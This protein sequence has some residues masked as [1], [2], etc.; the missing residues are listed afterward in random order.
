MSAVA[1]PSSGPDLWG[2]LTLWWSLDR[3]NLLQTIG[4]LVSLLAYLA[5]WP[6]LIEVGGARAVLLNQ[7]LHA[8]VLTWMLVLSLPVRTIGTREVVVAWLLG[9]F[10]VPTL[11]FVP[12][13]PFLR[14]L[15]SD[16]WQLA[17]FVAPVLEELALLAGVG[18]LTWRLTRRATRSPGLADLTIIG[19]AVGG[20]YAVHEDALYGRVL[21]AFRTGTVTEAFQ[22]PFAWL[23][24]TFL[25][26]Q[27]NQLPGL[28]PYH[29][30]RAALIALAVGVVLLLR[31]RVRG[32][33]VLVPAVL[34]F[35][36]LDH[37]LANQQLTF[38]RNLLGDLL[39]QG[40]VT[41]VLLTAAI[42]AALLLHRFGLRGR[43]IAHE[44]ASLAELRTITTLASGPREAVLRLLTYARFHR[45]RNAVLLAAWRDQLPA[46]PDD[47]G[48]AAWEAVTFEGL[49]RDPL[50]ATPPPAEPPPD[51]DAAP[52]PPSFTS[53]PPPPAAY[54]PP[55]PTP[56]PPPADQAGR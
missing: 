33:V 47:A 10:L 18:L 41:A 26:E 22:G 43:E 1:E 30:G 20:G 15:G 6:S 8:F 36:M 50:P 46:A 28:G 3:G 5:L 45:T 37:A 23:F 52:S 38:G 13:W 51:G 11:V 54:P 12:G 48:L 44:P 31:R 14:W 4:L 49:G 27:V 17:V 35:N 7:V 34:V 40:Y 32:I 42:P 29:G 21:G 53:S 9:T 55:P 24:P 56:P 16:S 25:D 39:G 19:F 2:R